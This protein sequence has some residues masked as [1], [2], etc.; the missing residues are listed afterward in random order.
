MK[1][2]IALF[3][4]IAAISTSCSDDCK[5]NDCSYHGYC[6]DGSCNCEEGYS[7]ESC[8]ISIAPVSVNLNE[9]SI[10]SFPVSNNGES[11]DPIGLEGKPDVY[12]KLYQGEKMLYKGEK[13]EQDLDLGQ[14]KCTEK[15]TLVLTDY[16]A[17]YTLKLYDKD[18]GEIVDEYMSAISFKLEDIARWKKEQVLIENANTAISLS[19]SFVY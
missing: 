3:I 1:N 6:L 14:H 12:F 11:W 13:I 5:Q 4:L 7:G 19:M 17:N 18:E 8:Q 15:V 16:Q 2:L 9:I 10:V